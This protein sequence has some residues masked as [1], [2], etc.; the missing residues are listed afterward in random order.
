MN[1]PSFDSVFDFLMWL[2][3]TAV[4]VAVAV[5]LALSLR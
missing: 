1:R 4:I 2:A 3:L 5:A